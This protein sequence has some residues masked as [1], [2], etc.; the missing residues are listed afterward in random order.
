MRGLLL[1]FMALSNSG[2]FSAGVRT[3]ARITKT[4][5]KKTTKTV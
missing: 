1:S 4:T 2:V 3:R 5:A